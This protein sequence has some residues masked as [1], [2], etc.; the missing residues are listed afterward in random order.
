MRGGA[1]APEIEFDLWWSRDNIPVVIHDIDLSRL[2]G[3]E[4]R[5][6]DMTLDEL[7]RI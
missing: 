4:G 6:L 7:R 5:V 2:A 3:V 1:G